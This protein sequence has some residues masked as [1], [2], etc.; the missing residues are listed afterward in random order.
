MCA[1]LRTF[2]I[3]QGTVNA[4]EAM[5]QAAQ[6]SVLSGVEISNWLY[7]RVGETINAKMEK[8]ISAFEK[9][10][11]QRLLLIKQIQELME[12]YIGK[13]EQ[14]LATVKRR[15]LQ[16]FGHFWTCDQMEG[17]LGYHCPARMVTG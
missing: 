10:N 7:T 5:Y 9:N 15:N 11:M 2:N 3:S 4:T 12:R 14:L 8:C 13:Q 17:E 6:S 16:W 1:N